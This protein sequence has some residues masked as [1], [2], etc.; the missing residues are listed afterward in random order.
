[1]VGRIARVGSVAAL[2]FVAFAAASP[3]TGRFSVV[4]FGDLYRAPQH[5]DP[6]VDGRH[7]TW[8]RRVNLTYDRDLEDGLSARV[9][10]EAKDPG[11]FSTS[12]DLEPF[13][14][15]LW[16]RWT[17]GD[18]RLTFGL[19][20]TPSASPAESRLGYRPIDKHTLDLF[21]MTS[22]RDKGLSVAGPLGRGGSG[23]YELVLG[24]A[25]GT[26]SSTG[27]TQAVYGRLAFRPAKGFTL[28][29]YGDWWDRKAGEEW[30]TWKAEATSVGR[31]GKLGLLWA[32]QRRTAPDKMERNL[33][34]WSV[35][36]EWFA[37]PSLRPF[38]WLH[39]A[40]DP[41]PDAQKIEYYRMSPDGKPTV[42]LAGVRCQLSEH[43]ELVPTIVRVEYRRA[44][45]EPK[46]DP[47][48]FLRL[49]FSA[50]F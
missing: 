36:G 2:W 30:T 9:N 3:D 32:T 23:E 34:V 28:D 12:S 13:F 15:D 6:S 16:V 45:S 41:I 21:R 18:H 42:W 4:L 11:D 39:V 35:Y 7:G 40:D 43:V 44:G 20:P 1:M 27:D 8:I 47:D 48:T 14:K 31:N 22:T 46:P 37:G 17:R 10:L 33:D 25:S 19:L 5:H 50:K 24:D 29:L 49:T 38:V 26:K